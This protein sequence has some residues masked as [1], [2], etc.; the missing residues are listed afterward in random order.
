MV[1][2]IKRPRLPIKRKETGMYVV[3]LPCPG[4]V[5]QLAAAPAGR[6]S[7]WKHPDPWL[8]CWSCSLRELLFSSSQTH[9]GH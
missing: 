5:F 8:C 4:Q 1:Q 2:Q 3:S 6:G 9:T 7:A